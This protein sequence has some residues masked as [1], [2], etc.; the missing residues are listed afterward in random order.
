MIADIVDVDKRQNRPE[1]LSLSARIRCPQPLERCT[2]MAGKAKRAAA[3]QGELSRRRK[4]GQRGPSGTPATAPPPSLQSSNGG[5]A[6]L[7]ME[8]AGAV[9][10]A[11]VAAEAKQSCCRAGATTHRAT[12]ASGPPEGRAAGGLQFR[13]RRVASNRRAGDGGCGCLGGALVRSLKTLIPVG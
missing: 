4:K 12:P 11:S 7:A 2:I 13:G 3:R 1:F 10:T 8:A 9:S 5:G 6:T